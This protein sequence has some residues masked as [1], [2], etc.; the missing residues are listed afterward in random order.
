MGVRVPPSEPSCGLPRSRFA[1]IRLRRA[2][3]DLFDRRLLARFDVV[4][5]VRE[6]PSQSI[7]Q[8]A[9]TVVLPDP[10]KPIR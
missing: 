6:R 8:E 2:S 7:G 10:I 1:Q 3:K 9:S 4:V 5:Q